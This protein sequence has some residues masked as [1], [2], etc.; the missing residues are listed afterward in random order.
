MSYRLGSADV[1]ML[2]SKSQ[3]IRSILVMLYMKVVRIWQC[4][5]A[6]DDMLYELWMPQLW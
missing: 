5:L 1:P 3:Y 6:D 2:V 4:L